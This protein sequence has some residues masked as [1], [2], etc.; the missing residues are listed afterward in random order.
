MIIRALPWASSVPSHARHQHPVM[1]A[2]STLSFPATT[3]NPGSHGSPIGP[4]MT[5]G[6]GCDEGRVGDDNF[7]SAPPTEP[8]GQQAHQ[9]V[10]HQVPFARALN[11]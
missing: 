7:L 2:I 5:K 9:L 8:V 1:R 6:V 10:Q 4:G 3:G 11:Q